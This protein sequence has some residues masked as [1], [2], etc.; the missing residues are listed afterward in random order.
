[1][2]TVIVP[3]ADPAIADHTGPHGGLGV[4]RFWRGLGYALGAVLAGLVAQGGLSSAVIAG[5]YLRLRAARRAMGDRGAQPGR[6]RRRDSRWNGNLCHR[7]PWP[8][9]GWARW[10]RYRA[11]W[12]R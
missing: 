10:I 8:P 2:L 6:N 12:P 5:G 4:Y 3:G 1:V 9:R 7:K 11:A